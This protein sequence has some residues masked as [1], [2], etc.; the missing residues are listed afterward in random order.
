MQQWA[1]SDRVEVCPKRWAVIRNQRACV[2]DAKGSRLG[3]V[4]QGEVLRRKG[5]RKEGSHSV[6]LVMYT[7]KLWNMWRCEAP[8]S[9]GT[10][11]AIA[12]LQRG[13]VLVCS[14]MLGPTL[15]KRAPPTMS[16]QI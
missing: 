11:P 2:N 3:E 9:S 7:A 13:N 6:H 14:C 16:S 1:A 5:C 4:V 8:S 12:S 15:P 10:S